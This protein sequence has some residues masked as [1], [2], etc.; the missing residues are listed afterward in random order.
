MACDAAVEPLQSQS[1]MTPFLA[2]CRLG[3]RDD[4]DAIR[5]TGY[6]IA[7]FPRN[8]CARE[9]CNSSVSIQSANSADAWDE[10]GPCT[11]AY[12]CRETEMG[13]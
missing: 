7:I 9:G 3:R 12:A 1:V 5:Q 2:L 4:I 10:E 6:S 13:A 8:L 11:Q